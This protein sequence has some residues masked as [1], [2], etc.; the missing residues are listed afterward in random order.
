MEEKLSRKL[1]VIMYADVVE[2]SRL[3]GEDEEGTHRRLSEYLDAY[4]NEI[5]NKQGRVVHFAGD[6]IL[7][8]FP[9]VS[10]ALA[11]A[12]TV[13]RDI[14]DRNEELADESRIQFRI[15]INLGEII[16][17]RDD[18]YGDG[19]NIAARLESLAEAGGICI[20]GIV[21]D[22]VSKSVRE[23][24][25]E[26][27]NLAFEAL[28][29][30]TLKNILEPVAVYRLKQRSEGASSGER[31]ALEVDLSLPERPSIA[32]LP[33]QSMSADPEQEF[34]ADGLTEDIITR[35]SYLRDLLVIAKTSAFAYKGRAVHVQ[36][37]SRDLG[38]AHILEGSVRKV[39]NRIRITA[40]LIDGSTGGHIWAQK[41]DRELTDVFVIQDEITLAIVGAM[42]V[43]LTDGEVARLEEGETH[44]LDAWEAFHQG[45]LEFL[46][47]TQE[48]NME[49]RRLFERAL[50]LD[51]DYLDSKVYLA[52]THCMDA[53]LGHVTDRAKALNHSRK[54]LEEIE[55]SGIESANAKH[56]KAFHYLIEGRHEEALKAASIAINLG[57]CR[58]FGFAPSAQVYMY[59]GDPK[60]ALDLMRT[61]MRLS[62][63]CGRDII[64]FLAYSLAWNGDLENAILAAE[65]YGRRVP[66]DIYAYVLRAM[67]Y[68][69]AG[70]YEESAI[71]VGTLREQFPTY[72]LDDFKSHESYR[73]SKDLE[74]LV[75]VLRKAGLPEH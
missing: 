60:S 54:L 47:Y 46:K 22:A 59:C 56:L 9:T 31:R 52:F 69:L 43:N 41:F 48:A 51:H 19:V 7:A 66:G 15:G 17:D 3:T 53:R 34:F 44:N 40:Q 2:Y 16:E 12:A 6:A 26:N 64:Y 55:A 68:G 39:G 36:D 10:D 67:V 20:S 18:I 71:I 58:M 24:L 70:N 32:V 23:E 11:C 33:F 72:S 65:E 74:R 30:Q 42:R 35:L 27:A 45:A 62:P 61:S 49:A 37:I 63:F 57:P 13:Q 14:A 1:A 21:Y 4:T 73:D 8:E 28:G 29:V 25:S 75:E 5:H 38:V 50:R